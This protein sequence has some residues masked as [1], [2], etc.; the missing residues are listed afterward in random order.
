MK[1]KIKSVFSIF[2][3]DDKAGVVIKITPY[4]DWV[5]LF[6]L[7]VI[8]FALFASV[9]GYLF[10]VAENATIPEA[11]KVA[12]TTPK[13]NKKNATTTVDMTFNKETLEKVVNDFVD[14]ETKFEQLKKDA[15]RVSDPSI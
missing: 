15:P 7:I 2:R 6:V 3:A 12:T 11:P 8:S 14:R 10:W 9:G 13:T 5:I 1:D 4:R